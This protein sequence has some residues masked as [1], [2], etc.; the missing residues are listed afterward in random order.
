V[1]EGDSIKFMT[2]YAIGDVQGCYDEL[3]N[4]LQLIH[5]QPQ[6][7]HL[8]FTGDLINRGSQSLAVLRFVKSLGDRAI[9]VLGNHDLHFLAVASGTISLKKTD[10]FQDILDAPDRDTLAAWLRQ[11]PLLYY[12]QRTDFTLV[13]AGIAPQWN[14]MQALSC[15]AEIEQVLQSSHYQEFFS[16]MYGTTPACWDP[17]LKGW[18]RWRFITNCFT[19]IR[20]VDFEGRLELHYK[21]PVGGQPSGFYPWF[22][23]PNR[24]NLQMKILFGHWA[25][26]QGKTNCENIYGIDTGCCWGNSLTAMRLEDSQLFQVKCEAYHRLNSLSEE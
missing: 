2:I 10:T 4:L 9:T 8:W 12:D 5:F 15:A 20:Y 11:Q 21:G 18:D 23:A 7:D 1:E 17:A 24:K 26:L 25:S 16:H 13:H 3:Q 19:R 14:L 22:E 6:H